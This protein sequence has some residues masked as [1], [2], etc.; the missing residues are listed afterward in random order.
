MVVLCTCS[1]HFFWVDDPTKKCCYKP[2]LMDH[3]GPWNSAKNSVIGGPQFPM[4]KSCSLS[5]FYTC[6][7]HVYMMLPSHWN[8]RLFSLFWGWIRQFVY[9]WWRTESFNC[10]VELGTKKSLQA[11]GKEALIQDSD[12]ISSGQ[13]QKKN[14]PD[15]ITFMKKN[16]WGNPTKKKKR[17]VVNWVFDI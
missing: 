5:D 16:D 9:S 6:I 10:L 14:P 13:L 4:E 7:I 3:R 15:Y 2:R 12:G 11:A 17:K 1:R 8:L